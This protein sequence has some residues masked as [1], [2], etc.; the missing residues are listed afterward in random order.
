MATLTVRNLPERVIRSLKEAARRNKRSMEQEA[1]YLLE[2]TLPDRAS[3]RAQIEASWA[4]QARPTS[5]N[6][7]AGWIRASRP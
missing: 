1:R 7:V 4:R 5:E 3:A 2:A 6:E